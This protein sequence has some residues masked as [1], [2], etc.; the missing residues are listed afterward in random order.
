ME[1][2]IYARIRQSASW[3]CSKTALARTVIFRAMRAAYGFNGV[4]PTRGSRP[5]YR[6]RAMPFDDPNA[7]A[8]L[9][10]YGTPSSVCQSALPLMAASPRSRVGNPPGDSGWGLEI[11][12][13]IQQAHSLAPVAKVVLVEANSNSFHDLLAA[14]DAAV[15]AGA[16][17]VSMSW[18]GGDFSGEQSYRFPLPGSRAWLFSTWAS[19]G[20]GGHGVEL[21]RCSSLLT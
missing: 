3:G 5:D 4:P 1:A 14:V 7:E 2:S 17:Q 12:L 16:T 10:V 11:S 6:H 15:A 9:Q 21:S 8:D 18:S 20:D 19:T 13:D